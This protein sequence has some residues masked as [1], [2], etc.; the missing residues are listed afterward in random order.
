MS[1]SWMNLGVVAVA[2]MW[3]GAG[4]GQDAPADIAGTWQGTLQTPRV[5]RN[6]FKISK[7]DGGGYKA[8]DLTKADEMA[9]ASPGSAEA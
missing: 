5:L 3:P 9:A 6:V 1:R 2:M 8:V 7:T 4:W